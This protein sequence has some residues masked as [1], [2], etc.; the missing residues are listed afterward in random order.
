LAFGTG[1]DHVKSVETVEKRLLGRDLIHISQAEA[2][3]HDGLLLPLEAFHRIH[4]AVQAGTVD[5]WWQARVEAIKYGSLLCPMRGNDP[6][7]SAEEMDVVVGEG[8]ALFEIQ[9][10]ATMQRQDETSDEIRLGFIPLTAIEVW[11][12][13]A[14]ER[15]VWRRLSRCSQDR[16]AGQSVGQAAASRQPGCPGAG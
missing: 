15:R 4:G 14:D 9:Q 16:S 12:D 8:I 10:A 3:E 11:V 2:G 7:A 5:A 1:G 13:K 6:N